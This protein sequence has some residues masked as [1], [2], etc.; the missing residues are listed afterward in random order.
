MAETA[1]TAPMEPPSEP[2][3]QRKQRRLIALLLI[4]VIL[5]AVVAGTAYILL[6]S[7]GP[8]ITRS[9]RIGVTGQDAATLN[10]N[11][12]TLVLEF[13][14]VYNVYSTLV[15]RDASYNVVGDL[16]Y[17]WE[18]A[19]DNVTWTFHLVQNAFFTDPSKP[20]DRSHP[21][22]ADDVVFSYNMLI[23]NDTSGLSG[24][25]TAIASVTRIDAYTVR[26]VTTEPYAAMDSTL[27]AVP[28][29]PK[30]LWE[31]IAD[32]VTNAPPV[33]VGSGA[34][35]YDTNSNLASG[36][37]ILRKNPNYYAEAQYCSVVRPDE[38]RFL[39]FNTGG[40]LADSFTSGSDNLDVIYSIPTSVFQSGLSPGQGQTLQK[41]AVEGG[42]VGEI[43][44]NQITPAIRAQFTDYQTG[45]N[46]P[47]L[48]NATVRK[49]VAMS[50]DK[51]AIVRYALLGL[52]TVA[53]TLVP[54]SNTW[55]YSI[56]S[57]DRFPFDTAAARKLLNDAGWNYTSTGAPA[58]PTTTPL[59]RVGPTDPLQFHFYMP[60]SHP[61]FAV[62]AANITRWL[63][64]SGIQTLDS[65]NRTVPGYEVKSLDAMNNA[66]KAADFDMWIWDWVF[67]P[68]SDPSTDVLSVQITD[69]IPDTSDSW[70]SNATYD[71]LYNDS[72]VTRD[73]AAR[74]TITDTMQRML[75]ENAH[76]ILPY[77]AKDLYAVTSSR[78]YG[79]GWTNWGD[80]A[81]QRGLVPDSDNPSLWF[82]I[83]PPD[84]PAPT[85]DSFSDASGSVG[86][87]TTLS[88]TA[89]DAND[90]TLSYTWDFGDGSATQTTSTSS[91]THTY[92]ATGNYAVKVRVKDAEW[93]VCASAVVRIGSATVSAMQSH[94]SV[95]ANVGIATSSPAGTVLFVVPWLIGVV[96]GTVLLERA[97]AKSDQSV[98]WRRRSRVRNRR[99]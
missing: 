19:A 1:P 51:A 49:A 94:Q 66:W 73:L 36:P 52:G 10:P 35:Y 91:V 54:A 42:F 39:Y 26:I 16:A 97:A 6:T 95:P 78:G 4:A 14:V 64:Q 96:I 84:N 32:P 48:L 71:S 3:K 37:I 41:Y 5:I 79:Y 99:Q 62:A 69:S 15:T 7:K 27:G 72:L 17:A 34:L 44:L 88:V 20:T 87:A 46:N 45:F 76:Y 82:R 55:H 31:S 58:T 89:S 18:I 13:I 65:A 29:F 22:T 61:E 85:I 86:T 93:P 23:Q 56:P 47:L 43:V 30:Y 57:A 90:A 68:I 70:Y 74:R 40:Q 9:L 24:Y 67:S 59:Y 8:P 53:D 2:G 92:T 38:I 33:P 12:I 83:S 60:D 25:V 81:Q 21:V 28:I 63:A 77:Y 98:S 75:Y 80:W 11:D 50:I